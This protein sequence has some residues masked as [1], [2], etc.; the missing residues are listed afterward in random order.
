[1][2]KKPP[3]LYLI[4]LETYR[5]LKIAAAELGVFISEL[6]EDAVQD[7]LRDLEEVPPGVRGTEALAFLRELRRKRRDHYRR[8]S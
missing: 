1:M 7:L 5:R 2:P 4:L 8:G 6:V 3:H